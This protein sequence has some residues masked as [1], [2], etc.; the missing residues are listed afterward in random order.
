MARAATR[1]HDGLAESVDY[2]A[3]ERGIIVF[4]KAKRGKPVAALVPVDAEELLEALEDQIDAH[5]ARKALEERS[6]P[7]EQV[8]KELGL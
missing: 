1:N 6:S 2:V 8:R 7:W 4:R 5:E 3:R